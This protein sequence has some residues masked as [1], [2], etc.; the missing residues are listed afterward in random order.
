MKMI[1]ITE[2]DAIRI[3]NILYEYSKIQKGL[4]DMQCNVTACYANQLV[5]RVDKT[6]ESSAENTSSHKL[7]A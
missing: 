2:N 4:G 5:A 1:Q 3:A 6:H 7:L